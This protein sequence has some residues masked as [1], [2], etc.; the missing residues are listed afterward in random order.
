MKKVYGP[1]LRKE[2]GLTKTIK[3]LAIK[4]SRMMHASNKYAPEI[5]RVL[6]TMEKVYED[7]TDVLDDFITKCACARL[8]RYGINSLNFV[9][10]ASLA[11]P[12]LSGAVQES[13]FLL[14]QS[15]ER[16]VITSVLVNPSCY[17]PT[18]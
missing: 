12:K 10:H 3:K 6:S 4:N 5:R 11:A 2:A 17:L 8:S 7:A 16:L 14:Q 15:R 1:S 13:K 9:L 18:S